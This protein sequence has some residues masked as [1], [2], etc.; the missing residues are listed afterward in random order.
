MR[1]KP[2]GTLD[3]DW[4]EARRPWWMKTPEMLNR[5]VGEYPLIEMMLRHGIPVTRASYLELNF[6]EGVPDPL[7][8][9]EEAEL[10]EPLQLNPEAS[11]RLELP[12][13]TVA[14]REAELMT[15]I[16]ANHPGVTR[17]EAQELLDSFF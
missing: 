16:L 6:P 4:R 12:Y 11:A 2:D 9:E 14:E 17:E 13:Q 3:L 10:P 7:P 8:A 15:E 5:L 1:V